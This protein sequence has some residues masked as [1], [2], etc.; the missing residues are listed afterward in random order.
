MADINGGEL[1]LQKQLQGF[2]NAMQDNL[3]QK[4]KDQLQGMILRVETLAQEIGSAVN[5]KDL[6][7]LQTE[8]ASITKQ[9]NELINNQKANQEVIDKFVSEYNKRES[10]NEKPAFEDAWGKMTSELKSKQNEYEDKIRSK[11]NK[12][13]FDLKTTMTTSNSITGGGMIDYNPR[14]GLVPSQK[15]NMRDLLPTVQTQNGLFVTYRETNT[16]QAFTEQTE[17]AT[18]A[19]VLYAFTAGTATLKYIAG[20]A[21]FSKQLM[22]HL[23]FINNTLPRMLTRDFYKKENSYIYTTM[24]AAAL[25]SDYTAATVD[26]E[27]IIDY[28]TNQR[29]ADFDASYIVTDW[30]EWGRLLKTKPSNYSLPAGTEVGNNGI[31]LTIAGT[32]IIGASFALSD[33]LLLW[34]RDYVERVEGE[35]LRVEFSYENNDN[36]EK[37]LVTA[38]CECFEEVNILRREAII[39]T[40]LGNS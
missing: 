22:F 32:P 8:I 36:F 2:F 16:A 40:D 3:E 12:L 26:V 35:S 31:P 4:Q 17:N 37:N 38:R 1:P 9:A 11:D 39:Y 19:N 20:Q 33:K 30:T 34:D 21:T 28:I 13:S 25:G 7:P 27:Q 10:K 18:K 24:A 5:K 23:P 15:V 29:D 6:E 14:Q